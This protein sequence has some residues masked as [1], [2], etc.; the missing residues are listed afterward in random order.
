MLYLIEY[1][2]KLLA[3]IDSMEILLSHESVNK[4]WDARDRQAVRASEH[5][6]LIGPSA[7]EVEFW[8]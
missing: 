2:I 7:K 8:A 5:V 1:F 6:V 4:V 3:Y